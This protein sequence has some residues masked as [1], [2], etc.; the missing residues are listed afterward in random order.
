MGSHIDIGLRDQV[1]G[2]RENV[3]G[4]NLPNLVGKAYGLVDLAIADTSLSRFRNMVLDAGH[5][6][7]S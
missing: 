6:V 7:A 1:K 4:R 5:A 3:S 2:C